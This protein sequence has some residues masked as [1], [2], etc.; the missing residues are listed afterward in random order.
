LDR[1]GSALA[2]HAPI[3]GQSERDGE[4]SHD[5]HRFAALWSGLESPATH[6]LYRARV[7]LLIWKALNDALL[8]H[9]AGGIDDRFQADGTLHA[10]PLGGTNHSGSVAV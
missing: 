8:D 6:R 2:R 4:D 10:A 3:L 9:F 5:R 1:L 7:Q